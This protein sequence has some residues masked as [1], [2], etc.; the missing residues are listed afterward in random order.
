MKSFFFL[1]ALALTPNHAIYISVIDVNHDITT[2]ESSVSVK[3]FQDDLQNA[4]RNFNPEYK[5]SSGEEFAKI[6]QLDI[7]KYFRKN[8]LFKTNDRREN[9]EFVS[10]EIENDA[11]F[12]NFKFKSSASLERIEIVAGFFTELFPDQSNVLTL[13]AGEKKYFARLTKTKP[14]Y[15][16]TFD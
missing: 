7:V 3:V 5:R 15:A 10:S 12:L 14:T 8:L 6:N 13:K 1:F 2:L 16:L 4:I 11:Y 9:L